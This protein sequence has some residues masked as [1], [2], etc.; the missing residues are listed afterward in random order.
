MTTNNINDA[1]HPYR[2]LAIH[3]IEE[4]IEPLIY[5]KYSDYK[6]IEGEEYYDLEGQLVDLIIKNRDIKIKK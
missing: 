5:R 1:Q 2:Q 4:I 6:G 3:I